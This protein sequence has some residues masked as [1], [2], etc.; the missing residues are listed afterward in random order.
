MP[1]A[2]AN[3]PLCTT[4]HEASPRPAGPDVT[5]DVAAR[6]LPDNALTATYVPGPAP[7]PAGTEPERARGSISVLGYE[8]EAVLGRG[9]MG[10]VYEAQ[11]LSLGRLVAIKVLPA[12]ALLDARHLGR[13]QREARSAAK[14]ASVKA[15]G[16]KGRGQARHELGWGRGRV[17]GCG[18]GRR[19]AAQGQGNKIEPT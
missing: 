6:A 1:P 10:V 4:D 18:A 13:F 2:E 19:P 16:G 7:G 11:Q 3:D 15:R 5:A 14:Q 12:H 9:G 17:A 8:I